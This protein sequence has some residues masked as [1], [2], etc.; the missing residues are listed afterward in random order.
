MARPQL[1]PLNVGE[2]LDATFSIYKSRFKTMVTI[3]AVVMIPFGIVSAI[4][5]ASLV[6]DIEA[7]VETG[8]FRAGGSIGAAL[9]VSVLAWVAQLLATAAV[10]EAVA[11]EYLGRSVTWQ[12]AFGTARTRL[13]PLVWGSLLIAIGVGIKR[14]ELGRDR[15][16][17]RRRRDPCQQPD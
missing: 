17:P 4:I 7:S 3:V 9:I 12:S 16:S 13:G 8:S 10:V 14:H 1:R 5:N 2:T 11:G 6:S 15:H